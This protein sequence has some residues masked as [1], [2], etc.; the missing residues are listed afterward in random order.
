MG[1][2]I[3]LGLHLAADWSSYGAKTTSVITTERSKL[4]QL[5]VGVGLHFMIKLPGIGIPLVPGV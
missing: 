2:P 5:T 4:E 3:G 1:L